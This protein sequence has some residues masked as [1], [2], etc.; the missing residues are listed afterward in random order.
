MLF[1][2]AMLPLVRGRASQ[3]DTG[4]AGCSR[5]A[6][7][8]PI[9]VGGLY[10]GPFAGITF[11][12][13]VAVVRDQVGEREDRFF[14]TVFLGSAILFVALLFVALAVATTPVVAVRYLDLRAPT[15]EEA[16]LARSLA[17]TL[18]FA[19]ATRAAAVFLF[20]T[21]TLGLRTGAFPSWFALTGY[22][23]GAILLL[24]VN[25]WDWVVLLLPAW[26]AVISV[27]ILRRE[28]AARRPGDRDAAP[29]RAKQETQG[30]PE[31]GAGDLGAARGV[32]DDG[33]RGGAGGKVG[34]RP[35]V[36]DAVGVGGEALPDLVGRVAEPAGSRL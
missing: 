31:V 19:F 1:T 30:R 18:L 17:Y 10:L 29:G 3:D 32:D 13:F 20:S 22:V 7:A 21:A 26:V 6:A 28:R 25:F 36:S 16:R 33:D 2:A 24:V 12:W 27:S 9:V 8:W 4:L 11:L 14:A 23:A 35:P 5:R 34:D 15:A